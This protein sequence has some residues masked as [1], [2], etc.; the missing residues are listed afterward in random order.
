MDREAWCAAVHGVAKSQ[1]RPSDWLNW[2]KLMDCSPPRLLWGRSPWDFLGKT[3]EVAISFSK[4]SSQPRDQTHISCIVAGLFTTEQ[5]EKP[6]EYCTNVNFLLIYYSHTECPY[7]EPEEVATFATSCEL[8]IIS[9]SKCFFN[10]TMISK[11]IFRSKF[12][13]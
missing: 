11:S 4:G 5:P 8:I 7:G 9:Q 6:Q 10:W 1:T 12:I 2:T 13:I 3:P